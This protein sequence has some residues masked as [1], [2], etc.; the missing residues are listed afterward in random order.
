MQAPERYGAKFVGSVRWSGLHDAVAGP[1]VMQQE[2]TIGVNDLVAQ[3]RGNR[4][5]SAID[6]RSRRCSYHRGHM[7]YAAPDVL[8]KLGADLRILG[9]CQRHVARRRHGPSDEL[10]EMIDVH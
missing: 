8:K 10:R 3:S 9:L 6:H 2:V 4:V 7:T 5:G 1:N